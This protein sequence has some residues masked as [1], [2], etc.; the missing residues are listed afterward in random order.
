MKP[1]Q[2]LSPT[3]Q[4]AQYLEEQILSGDLMGEMPGMKTLSVSIGVNHKTAEGAVRLLESKGLV[5][6]N[7]TGRK[8]SIT[9]KNLT[10]RKPLKVSILLGDQDDSRH[11]YMVDLRD[12]LIQAGHRARFAPKSLSELG[13]NPSRIQNMV[14]RNPADAW[15]VQAASREVLEWF[16]QQTFPAFSLFG[17]FRNIPI[18]ATGTSKEDAIR[19]AVRELHQLGHRRIVML[20]QEEQ[21]LPYPGP[22]PRSFLEALEASGIRPGCY[23]LPYWQTDGDSFRQC[24]DSLFQHTPP[25]ALF[26]P[27]APLFIAAQQHLASK[28]IMAPHQVSMICHDPSSAFRFCGPEISHISYDLNPCIRRTVEWLKHVATGK[29]DQRQTLSKSFFVRGG[30]IGPPPRQAGA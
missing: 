14:K 1:L 23:N 8:R 3:E 18:P 20:V 5:Y 21:C 7:G 2:V 24:L 11:Y 9:P 13:M 28:G 17:R 22:I 15:I 26:I 12:K 16:S 6:S 19:E 29:P 4:V 10:K 25:T 30:T 27:E